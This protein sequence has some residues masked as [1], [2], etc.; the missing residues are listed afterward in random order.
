[1]IGAR[2]GGNGGVAHDWNA[3]LAGCLADY[4]I[5]GL[6]HQHRRPATGGV[7]V[8]PLGNGLVGPR[9]EAPDAG[10]HGAE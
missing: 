8:I 1:M 7:G 3:R 2:G 5:A 6:L 10:A 4:H 9:G